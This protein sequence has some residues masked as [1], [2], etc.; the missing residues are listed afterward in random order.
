MSRLFISHSSRNDAQ[1][2]ALQEWLLGAGWGKDDI[3]LDISPDG[4]MAAG[5]RWVDALDDAQRR[6]E[7]IIFL[8]SKDWLSAKW[9]REE[10]DR[11]LQLNKKMFALI[12]DPGVDL[13]DLPTGLT[14]QWQ[15]VSIVSQKGKDTPTERFDTQ[16][17][18]TRGTD[19][20]RFTLD[21]LTR[22]RHGLTKAAIAPGSFSLQKDPEGPLGWRMP[23]RGLEPLEAKDAA[24]FFGR[25]V[26]ITQ[27]LDVL[28]GLASNNPPRFM[29]ILGA[30]G[31]GK[32]SYLRAGLLPRLERDDANWLPL[33]PLRGGDD[34]LIEAP[35]GLLAQLH[36][37]HQRLGLDSSRASLRRSVQNGESFINCLQ[38]L[39]QAAHKA[40]LLSKERGGPLPVLSIDQAEELFVSDAHEDTGRFLELLRAAM[41]AGELACIATIRSDRYSALQSEAI[42]EGVEQTTFSLPPVV[43]GQLAQIINGPAEVWRREAGPAA[44]VFAPNVSKALMEEI[45]GQQDALPLLAFAMARLIND[46]IG[47]DTTLE[48]TTITLEELEATGG[49]AKTIE[50]EANKA[51]ADAGVEKDPKAR[52]NVLRDTF[53]PRLARVDKNSRSFERRVA[54]LSDFSGGRLRELVNAF[55]ERRLLT[56]KARDGSPSVEVAHEALLRKWPTLS[57]ILDA[58]KEDL[59]RLDTALNSAAQWEAN[60]KATDYIDHRGGRLEDLKTLSNKSPEWNT[61]LEPTKEYVKECSI[62]TQNDLKRRRIVQS[63]FLVLGCLST[64]LLFFGGIQYIELL[65][66]ESGQRAEIA[67]RHIIDGKFDEARLVVSDKKQSPLS[68]NSEKFTVEKLSFLPTISKIG[69]TK[70]RGANT[71]FVTNYGK[72][73]LSDYL[74]FTEDVLVPDRVLPSNNDNLSIPMDFFNIGNVEYVVRGNSIYKEV[75]TDRISPIYSFENTILKFWITSQYIFFTTSDDSTHLFKITDHGLIYL[76]SNSDLKIL[77]VLEHDSSINIL[78]DKKICELK[79]QDFLTTDCSDE[80]KSKNT[81]GKIYP[82]DGGKFIALVTDAYFGNAYIIDSTG[83]KKIKIGKVKELTFLQNH[84][85]VVFLKEEDSKLHVL[86]AMNGQLAEVQNSTGVSDFIALEFTRRIRLIGIVGDNHMGVFSEREMLIEPFPVGSSKIVDLKEYKDNSVLVANLDGDVLQVKAMNSLKE[87]IQIK[88]R[89]FSTQLDDEFI[90]YVESAAPLIIYNQKSMNS[91]LCASVQDATRINPIYFRPPY[92]VNQSVDLRVN[93]T[94]CNTGGS[95]VA[96]STQ[97]KEPISFGRALGK[98]SYL[99]VGVTGAVYTVTND[100]NSSNQSRIENHHQQP[101]INSV[102]ELKFEKTD[103]NALV[104]LDRE[105][106]INLYNEKS[107]KTSLLKN[108][109]LSIENGTKP[110]SFFAISKTSISEYIVSSELD[111]SIHRTITFKSSHDRISNL[112]DK[113]ILSGGGNI[114][115]LNTNIVSDKNDIVTID[116]LAGFEVLDIKFSFNQLLAKKNKTLCIYDLFVFESVHCE[117]FD[118]RPIAA[119]LIEKS[120]FKV[121][122]GTHHLILKAAQ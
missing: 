16:H 56:L 71:V 39:R 63:S 36:L 41:M 69:G 40:A 44:P 31:A 111:I 121:W 53:I 120:S 114:S 5:Q 23:Y 6:C 52:E 21:G 106:V 67:N 98:S 38:A 74:G 17:P 105:G 54:S 4:G 57:K 50:L 15:A 103:E 84:A 83:V 46:H 24:V 45:S 91:V 95:T 25:D 110:S 70:R 93:L 96:L 9:C 73:Y 8:V 32:S 65:K 112:D 117:T 81:T 33:A 94:N 3:Y 34:G 28:R 109:I 85:K 51:L 37:L 86:D 27:G 119:R 78:V 92:L 2:L 59:I 20:V 12:I 48:A 10:Y 13:S 7:A 90:A 35:E 88:H 107:V 122:D 100:F 66:K 99:L 1:A 116:N 80:T 113:L 97:V 14:S 118:E 68:S 62:I 58:E 47:S 19:M 64:L 49:V 42:L 30:S 55:V 43:S 108:D 18:I 61:A 89:L 102:L 60:G 75:N 101:M 79:I 115:I 72:I 26:E 82:I 87:E 11:A 76:T 29:V 104:I 77:D 22:L